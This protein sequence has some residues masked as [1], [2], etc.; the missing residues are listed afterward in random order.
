LG[1][2][3]VSLRESGR[4]I[5]VRREDV[6]D[7]FWSLV[8]A[9][10]GSDGPTPSVAIELD[11]ER[12][13]ARL[14]WLAPAC[15]QEGISIGWGSDVA[16]LVVSNRE[17]RSRL[18]AAL[19]A[20]EVLSADDVRERLAAG[21]YRR[22]LREFQVQDLRHL[23]GLPNGANFSVPGAGKTAVEL[24]CFA[25]ERA[26][27]RVERML[28][29]A[30]I[31]AY[32]SWEEELRECFA[33]PP[34]LHIHEGGSVPMSAEIILLNY[35]RLLYSY[36][37]VAAWV[38]GR[39][40]LLCLDEAHRIKRGRSG[41]W[42]SACL[43]L[44]YLA[45]RRDV[46][47]GTP[48]PQSPADIGVLLDFLW[49]GQGSRILPSSVW[50]REPPPGVGRQVAES[51]APLF[52]RTTKS[53]LDLPPVDHRVVPVEPN[54]LQR[55]IY[56][57]LRSRFAPRRPLSLRQRASF[58][59]LGEIVMYLLEAATNPGLLTAGSSGDDPRFFRHPPL[60]ITADSTLA[61]LLARYAA[62]ET[63]SKF[64]AL[65]QLLA[66]NREEGRKTLVWSNFVRNLELLRGELEGL[67]PAV[68]HGGVPRGGEMVGKITREQEL[69]RFREDPSCWVL[70]ANPAALG[71]GVSLHTVCHDA[72]YLDRTF[73]AGQYLQSIDRI[74]RL[75]LGPEVETRVTFLVTPGTIDD[76]VS[77]RVAKKAELMGQMLD[78]TDIVTLALPDE[79]DVGAPFDLGDRG[80][81]ESLFDHLA[82]DG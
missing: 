70:L 73:N 56:E 11:T 46:L 27:G 12:F 35:Q 14:G 16:A 48:A 32:E 61:E 79:D 81:V 23:I 2:L 71:E 10:W 30:P 15:R 1:R 4:T 63:P 22:V 39:P 7:E 29:A 18:E 52:V 72:V 62:H 21:G 43:D 82:G 26:L 49:L 44:A 37:E 24:A 34:N 3:S 38:A 60:P 13:L 19:T 50:F 57:A 51:I 64:V 54:V 31:S 25:A 45:A 6:A 66:R 74:H 9:H 42:G 40:T 47:T 53:D 33:D 78:D 36:P 20:P 65:A 28:V 69:A 41:G 59:R 75:G 67:A 17:E 55:E 8:R 77:E 58:S 76:A 80:D 68:I 5:E